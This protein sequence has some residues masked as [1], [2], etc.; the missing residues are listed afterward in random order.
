MPT[1]PSSAL[2]LSALAISVLLILPDQLQAQQG[3][4]PGG[5]ARTTATSTGRGA[6]GA[7]TG[8]GSSTGSNRSSGGARQ[9]RSNTELG[10]AIITID[11]ETRSLVIVT[12]EDTHRELVTVI[13]SLDQP[14]PQVLIKVVFLEITYNKG[15]DIGVEGSYTFNLKNPMAATTGSSTTTT[16]KTTTN[17][18][19]TTTSATTTG[20]PIGTG[21]G[22]SFAGVNGSTGSSTLA[23]TLTSPLGSAASI[24]QSAQIQSLYGLAGLTSGSFLRLASDDWSATLRAL[25]TKG[26][27]EVLSRPSIMARNNQEAVIVVGSEVPF[28]T[29]SRITDAGQTINTIQYDNVGII[30]RVT[31][32]ITSEGT[33]EMIV[34]P[35]ISTLTDQTV[36][37]SNN[38][39]APVIAKRSAETVVVVPHGQT[40]VIGGLMETQKTETIQKFPILGDIPILGIPFRHTVKVDQKRELLIF[41]TPYIVNDANGLY[42]STSDEVNRSELMDQ[43]FKQ[44]DFEKYLDAPPLPESEEAQKPGPPKWKAPGT[45]VTRPNKPAL[46]QPPPGA[47]P[48]VEVKPANTKP[49]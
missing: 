34:A 39:S 25:A 12:D 27:L 6:T 45:S 1:S 7:R 5:A 23:S 41:L 2:A 20:S 31:P 28:I 15:L 14:K 16:T 37:I 43:A 11:P 13:R 22:S 47:R 24:G 49:L 32:F 44:K 35:E 42:K 8:T 18:G 30:L 33:I 26:K 19:T 10:D 29:N 4:R 36:P 40:A 48:P 38:A 46:V 21:T 3:A 17:N 9:Y